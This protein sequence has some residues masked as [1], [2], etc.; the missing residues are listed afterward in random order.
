MQS[1]NSVLI[2]NDVNV[3]NRGESTNN[4]TEEDS[5]LLNNG[6]AII[7]GILTGIAL[8]VALLLYSNS[9]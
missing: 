1:D 5:S 8:M 4:S 9:I 6:T 3:Q 7:L 2:N